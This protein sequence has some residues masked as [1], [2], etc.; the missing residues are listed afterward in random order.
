MSFSVNWNVAGTLFEYEHNNVAALDARRLESVCSTVR[1]ALGIIK[2]VGSDLE[3]I[4]TPDKC[5]LFGLYICP[6]VHNVKTKIEFFQPQYSTIVNNVTVTVPCKI[7]VNPEQNTLWLNFEV[8]TDNTRYHWDSWKKNFNNTEYPIQIRGVE[9]ADAEQLNF[10]ITRN[11][12]KITLP[13][14]KIELKKLN[15]VYSLSRRD[16]SCVILR[17]K[18]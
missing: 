2:G 8:I 10:Q 12:L 18:K 1:V 14:Q 16:V 9:G 4:V 6:T 5:R 7:V 17:E 15:L 11:Q 3:I 13:Q